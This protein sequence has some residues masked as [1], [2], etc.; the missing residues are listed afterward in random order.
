MN[1]KP[2]ATP[3]RG[4]LISTTSLIFYIFKEQCLCGH[5]FACFCPFF[6]FNDFAE[7]FYS[8]TMPAYFYQR[9]ND[10]THH[11]TKKSV[12]CYLKIPTTVSFFYPFRSSDIAQCGLYICMTFAEGSEI[13]VFQ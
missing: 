2:P 13:F 8:R 11:I 5:T 3:L 4:K 9:S 7:I 12:G 10:G 1:H 6:T